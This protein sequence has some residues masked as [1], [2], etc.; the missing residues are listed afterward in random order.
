MGWI[1]APL[2]KYHFHLK[3]SSLG[4]EEGYRFLELEPVI[5]MS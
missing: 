5:I 4:F 3:E 1:R 2:K